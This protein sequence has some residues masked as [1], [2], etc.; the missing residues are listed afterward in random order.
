MLLKLRTKSA[1]IIQSHIRG[2]LDRQ[3]ATGE[4]QCIV[5]IQVRYSIFVAIYHIIPFMFF[6][7]LN[8]FYSVDLHCHLMWPNWYQIRSHTYTRFI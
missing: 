8:F 3:K 6:F 5:V 1:V 7:P 4:K 2:W